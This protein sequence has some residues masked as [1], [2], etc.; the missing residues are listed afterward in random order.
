MET[1]LYRT[2]LSNA[3]SSLLMGTSKRMNNT[4]E[5][6]PKVDT[7]TLSLFHLFIDFSPTDGAIDYQL[8]GMLR[9]KLVSRRDE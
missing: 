8:V 3:V 4:D 1:C 9:S 6:P 5:G 2:F 7:H